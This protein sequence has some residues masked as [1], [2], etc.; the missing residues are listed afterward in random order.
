MFLA[1]TDVSQYITGHI[2]VVDGGKI[3]TDPN[4]LITQDSFRKMWSRGA[5]LWHILVESKKKNW[6]LKG[7]FIEKFQYYINIL[8]DK[9]W[10]V[11]NDR[12][13]GLK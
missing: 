10:V 13:H 2:I 1:A 11:K 3:L 8:Y 12:P 6:F 7:K 5:K 4:S 9:F